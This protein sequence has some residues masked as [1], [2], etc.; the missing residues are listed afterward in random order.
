MVATRNHVYQPPRI[1]PSHRVHE[2]VHAVRGATAARTLE[3]I[4][5][6]E[7][8]LSDVTSS[9]P[10]ARFSDL[11]PRVDAPATTSAP[12]TSPVPTAPASPASVK[13]E[14]VTPTIP[15]LC[16]A[17]DPP[18][19]AADAAMLPSQR[20]GTP[21]VDFG[22]HPPVQDRIRKTTLKGKGKAKATAS[23]P[24]PSPPCAVR[25]AS[26]PCADAATCPALIAPVATAVSITPAVLAVAAPS[27]DGGE[28]SNALRGHATSAAPARDA[29][30]HAPFSS[31][32]NITTITAS[33]PSAPATAPL[34]AGPS[35]RRGLLW[36]AFSLRGPSASH[37]TGASGVPKVSRPATSPPPVLAASA[38]DVPVRPP[39]AAPAALPPT[40]VGVPQPATAL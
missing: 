35:T 4:R 3:P 23:S 40:D 30:A 24:A 1:Q 7:S 36:P 18:A 14:S 39:P 22:G 17:T 33:L 6:A 20:E 11:F 9:S 21:F 16:A 29:P 5:E 38:T 8:P 12:Q 31:L 25:D 13:S 34:P 2:W 15:S 32:S 37:T 19:P 26:A 10:K 28:P 27:P